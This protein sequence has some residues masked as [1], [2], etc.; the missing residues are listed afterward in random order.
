MCD[1]APPNIEPTVAELCERG[2]LRVLTCDYG[3]QSA[4]QEELGSVLQRLGPEEAAALARRADLAAGSVSDEGRIAR[5]F[6]VKGVAR[7]V[8]MG[9]N[10]RADNHHK[11]TVT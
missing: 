8:A 2:V 11:E 7:E 6:A 5:W 4:A 3:E 9:G 10:E 1:W